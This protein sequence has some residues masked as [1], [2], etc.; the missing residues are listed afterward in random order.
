[1]ISLNTSWY[2]SHLQQAIHGLNKIYFDIYSSDF[3]VNGFNF[4]KEAKRLAYV[5]VILKKMLAANGYETNP[6]EENIFDI[7]FNDDFEVLYVT[8][9]EKGEKEK[10]LNI[11]MSHFKETEPFAFPYTMSLLYHHRQLRNPLLKWQIIFKEWMPSP[12]PKIVPKGQGNNNYP[13][14]KCS[15][16]LNWNTPSLS[17]LWDN[18][19]GQLA[20]L[21]D[22]D[23][24]YD[25]G[26]FQFNLLQYFPPC[27]KP[28]GGRGPGF[29]NFSTQINGQTTVFTQKEFVDSMVGEINSVGE[30]IGDWL[31]SGNALK[32][33]ESKIFDMDD[34]YTHVLNYITPDLLYSKICK[35]FIDLM[36]IDDISVPNLEINATGGSG[37][38]TLNPDSIGKN[39]KEMFDIKGPDVST[40]FLDEDGNAKNWKD[41]IEQQ[42]RLKISIVLSVLECQVYF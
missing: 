14:S 22:L 25:L 31:S 26:A 7:G 37:G 29:L 38:L 16:F 4:F 42:L 19:L 21:L 39:P 33:I 13:V 9:K 10:L 32:E 28:P 34:L 40:S 36:D 12:K 2:Q 18:A 5:P 6:Q 41:W 27:P 30:Y 3:R 15:P 20:D 23:P 11:G 24:R 35:C 8:Y 1:M 17:Q